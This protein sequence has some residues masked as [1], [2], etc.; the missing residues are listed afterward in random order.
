M[1]VCT[2]WWA[3]SKLYEQAVKAETIV[4]LGLCR[5]F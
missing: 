1:L 2:W 3:M 5:R 4:S